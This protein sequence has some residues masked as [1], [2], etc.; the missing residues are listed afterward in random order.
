M[1]KPSELFGMTRRELMANA[2]GIS[3]LGAFSWYGYQYLK[4][5]PPKINIYRPGLELGHLMRDR[6]KLSD[7]IT[8]VHCDVLIAGSGA[9]A[10]T[11][12]WK[13]KREG[14][15]NFVMLEGPEPDGNNAGIVNEELRYPTAAH[16]F[17]L[18]SQE[19]R[20]I[21]E[22]LSDIGVLIGDPYVEAPEY[23]EMVL[24]HALE[25]RLLRNGVWQEGLLP[26]EDADSRRFFQFIHELSQMKGDDGK[27][28]FAIPIKLS[29]RDT[30]W[31]QLDKMTFV[32][33]L[34]QEGYTS[35]S[36]L[37]Y[38]NY[39]C[40]DDY[41]QGIKHVSAWAGLH[42]FA[43]RTGQAKHAGY[44][45]VLTWPDGLATFNRKLREYVGFERH[46]LWKAEDMQNLH[47][48][49]VMAGSVLNMTEYGDRVELLVAVKNGHQRQTYQ[50]VKV[51]AGKVISAMPLYMASYVVSNIKEY[52]FN[53]QEHLPAYGPWILSNFVFDTYPQELQGASLAWD[54]VVL[55]SPGLG[56]VVST[57][58]LIR[59]AKPERTAFTAYYP[60][61]EDDPRTVRQWMMT[62]TQ[63]E[64]VAKAVCDLQ[65][66]YPKDLW[67]HLQQIDITL[68]GHAMASP[69]PG[70]RSNAGLQTLQQY[71]G[72]VVFAHSDLSGYSVIEEAAW[73]GVQAA[74]KVLAL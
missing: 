5:V 67:Q 55:D 69:T 15:S 10:L 49:A 22:M 64:L 34:E 16:Y 11:A 46:E 24:V 1:S 39:C 30:G 50:T 25:E 27:S 58:Q 51:V 21:R 62:A 4:P 13:L 29:S 12:A 9:S 40:R 70:Y 19:S 47:T 71:N 60:M 32:Q 59:A 35:P 42:Y 68:R 26:E 57:H 31:L 2:I 41:G 6:Q 8:T 74:N 33:W 38:L 43:A 3:A 23:D 44:G 73:W 14:F 48:P 72:R 37:W 65:Q 7:P 17:A 20:H 36:L 66:A 63:D 56:Y 28:L 52:G 54:N 45:A 53:P 61:D 18:P